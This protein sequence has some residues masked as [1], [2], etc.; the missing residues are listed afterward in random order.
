MI[1]H[2]PVITFP[3]DVLP[4]LPFFCARVP[5]IQNKNT[6]QPK[7]CPTT[8]APFAPRK[9]I[10][11]RFLKYSIPFTCLVCK[12]KKH[13]FLQAL[14]K[15]LRNPQNAV[16]VCRQAHDSP[17]RLVPLYTTTPCSG[18]RCRDA[19]G[20]GGGAGGRS[21]GT[22]FTFCASAARAAFREWCSIEC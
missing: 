2:V 21:S 17:R 18:S 14:Q 6:Y 4:P 5:P 8:S 9:G 16:R 15:I 3:N 13:V 12:I 11:P 20:I 7:K 22:G 19:S 1:H 10:L